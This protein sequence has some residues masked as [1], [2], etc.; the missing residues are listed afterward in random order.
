M[1]T[2]F[3]SLENKSNERIKSSLYSTT[4]VSSVIRMVLGTNQEGEGCLQSVYVYL[5]RYEVV[6]HPFISRLIFV[7]VT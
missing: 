6:I 7:L 5:V 3:H 2:S 1:F 4:I